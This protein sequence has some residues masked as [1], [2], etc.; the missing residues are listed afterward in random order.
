MI[1]ISAIIREKKRERLLKYL[2]IYIITTTEEENRY[3]YGNN[4]SR[5]NRQCIYLK[6]PHTTP[7]GASYIF[8]C[9]KISCVA[10]KSCQRPEAG[11]R[12][13]A[14]DQL[15]SREKWIPKNEEEEYDEE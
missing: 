7:S 13:I 12:G 2:G 4:K 14:T 11:S 10:P 15:N 5:K 3:R 1:N 9:N 6:P 8:C